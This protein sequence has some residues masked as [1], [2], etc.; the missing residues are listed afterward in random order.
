[1]KRIRRPLAVLLALC[2]LVGSP[3]S[4]AA[5]RISFIRDAEIENTIRTFAT[6]IF[7]AAGLNPSSVE[8]YLVNDSSINAFVAGGQKLFIHSGLLM[9]S[10]TA[11]QVIGV[12]AHEVGHIQGGHLVR[13]HDAMRQATAESILAMVVGLA[14]AVATGRGDMGTAVA[15]GGQDAALRS[16][17]RYSRTQEGAADSAAMR[18]LDATGQSSQG[19]LEFFRKLE[20]QEL[21]AVGRQDPYLRTHPLSRDRMIAIENHLRHSR[22]SQ[23]ADDPALDAMHARMIAKLRGFIEPATV[24]FR[25]YPDNDES[26]EARYARTLAYHKSNN[27]DATLREID[28]LISERPDDPYFH[29]LKGQVLFER[30]RVDGALRSYERAATLAPSEALIRVELARVQLATEDPRQFEPAIRN[31]RAALFRERTN[32]SVWKELAIAYGRNGQMGESA[33]AMAEAAA[34]REN[35]AEARHHA[36]KAEGMLPQGSSEWLQSQDI[37]A[38]AQ[39]AEARQKR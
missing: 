10:D 34:R 11:N 2:F 22:H 18:L 30:G 13:V 26:I 7:E 5:K 12:I 28:S 35:W 8:I 25:R 33:W 21:L 6:P 1:M 31:L 39:R 17:L 29:E 20:D 3:L 16:F 27:L 14:A 19:L 38:Q 15:A 4:A 32:P 24:T 37:I 36:S 23:A 9:Q